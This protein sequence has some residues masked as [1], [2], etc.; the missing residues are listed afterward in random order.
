[1]FVVQLTRFLAIPA[2]AWLAGQGESSTSLPPAAPPLSLSSRFDTK[3][4]AKATPASKSV[5]AKHGK[6]ERARR[7][8]QP[9]VP[10]HKK[11]NIGFGRQVQADDDVFE[12]RCWVPMRADDTWA[13]EQQKEQNLLWHSY[14]MQQEV[15]L[16]RKEV[17]RHGGVSAW[18]PTGI[19][20]WMQGIIDN[21]WE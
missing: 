10:D 1:M 5:S 7:H 20:H 8:D 2:V 21:H 12:E 14:K 19:I 6:K 13:K 4:R 11:Q 17:M 9:V 18:S 15:K 16:Q 3:A